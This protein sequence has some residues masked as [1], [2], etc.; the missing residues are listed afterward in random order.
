MFDIHYKLNYVYYENFNTCISGDV[1]VDS[2]G[3]PVVGLVVELT[4]K[5]GRTA[6]TKT[7]VTCALTARI[8]ARTV[9]DARLSQRGTE[10]DCTRWSGSV[11]NSTSCGQPPGHGLWTYRGVWSSW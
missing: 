6:G 5:V 2:I 7:R 3:L 8:L 10:L 9:L 11:L 1:L 4:G